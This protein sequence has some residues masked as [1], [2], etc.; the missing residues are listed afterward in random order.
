[1]K[2]YQEVAKDLLCNLPATGQLVIRRFEGK[3]G[4]G[5][6]DLGTDRGSY[7]LFLCHSHLTDM[8]YQDADS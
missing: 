8:A 7:A 3:D 1:M 6:G 4:D 2:L 5:D